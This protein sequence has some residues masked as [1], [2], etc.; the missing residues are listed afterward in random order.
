MI[1]VLKLRC[2]TTRKCTQE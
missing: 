2:I 1:L